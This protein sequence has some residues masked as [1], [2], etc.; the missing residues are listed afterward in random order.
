MT[1]VPVG[2]VALQLEPKL[3][4]VVPVAWREEVAVLVEES[5]LEV[6]RRLRVAADELLPADLARAY[7]AAA[8]VNWYFIAMHYPHR[9]L[10]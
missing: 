2:G 6:A 4:E 8:A 3:T 5:E 9:F 1:V 7:T 10:Q